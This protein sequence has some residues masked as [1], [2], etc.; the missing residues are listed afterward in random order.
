[1]QGKP[2]LPKHS[3]E[4]VKREEL[5]R[6]TAK[7][8]AGWLQHI[9]AAIR[10]KDLSRNLIHHLIV[11]STFMSVAQARD[12]LRKRVKGNRPFG[13]ADVKKVYCDFAGRWW[14]SLKSEV[15]VKDRSDGS[16][17][18]DVVNTH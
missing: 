18:T 9:D 17:E 13:P 8:T 10:P 12:G 5:D 14:A 7:W 15:F 11:M 6:A 16:A 2:Y 4:K 1:M 3:G